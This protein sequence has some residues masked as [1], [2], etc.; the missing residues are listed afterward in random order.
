MRETAD[1]EEKL[2]QYLQQFPHRDEDMSQYGVCRQWL[3]EVLCMESGKP[4]GC[5]E[6][7]RY[8]R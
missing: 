2:R 5:G 4:C 3:Q 1:M 8:I 6:K 7:H